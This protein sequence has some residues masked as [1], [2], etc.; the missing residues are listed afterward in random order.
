MAD[1]PIVLEI[2]ASSAYLALARS[3]AVA[4]CA[5]ADYPLDRMD[6]VALAVNE[7]CA[8]RLKDAAPGARIRVELSADGDGVTAVVSAR[9]RSGRTPRTTS[10]SW[11]VLDA[12]VDDLSARVVADGVELRLQTLRVGAPG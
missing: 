3:A 4:V 1:R 7:A 11:T 9:T 10:F 5:R 8:L 12:L 2:P 6:D